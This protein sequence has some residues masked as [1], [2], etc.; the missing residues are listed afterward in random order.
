MN[1]EIGQIKSLSS[2]SISTQESQ[3]R[4]VSLGRS[5]P[6]LIKDT[7]VYE[8]LNTEVMIYD[9][10]IAFTNIE[11]MNIRH[12]NFNMVFEIIKK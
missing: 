8:D 5:S 7:F 9:E 6:Y 2:S 3:T 11:A 4:K 10:F 1:T 12:F